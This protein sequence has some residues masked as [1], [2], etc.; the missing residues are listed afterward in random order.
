MYVSFGLYTAN[1]FI[2]VLLVWAMPY[3]ANHNRR[4]RKIPVLEQ[5]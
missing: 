1:G 5:I 4:Q 2:N 3:T